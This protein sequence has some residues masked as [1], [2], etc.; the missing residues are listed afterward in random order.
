MLL[1]LFYLRYEDL[2]IR[3]SSIYGNS[4]CYKII[5]CSFL[6]ICDISLKFTLNSNVKHRYTKLS[7][8][9][10]KRMIL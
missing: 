2:I 6:Y 3:I 4:S 5:N 1:V 8:I 10:M 7:K 9:R